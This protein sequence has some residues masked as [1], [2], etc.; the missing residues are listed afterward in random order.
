MENPRT[1]HWIGLREN[2]Q[3]NTIFNMGKSMVSCRF[4]LKPIHWT[5]GG[6]YWKTIEVNED[7]PAVLENRDLTFA[8]KNSETGD[9]KHKTL[10]VDL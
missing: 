9:G 6:R 8:N 7:F 5:K 1:N 3:E 2:L 10:L 4:S